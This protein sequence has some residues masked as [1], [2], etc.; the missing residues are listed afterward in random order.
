MRSGEIER[1][2]WLCVV[3]GGVGWLWEYVVGYCGGWLGDRG[4]SWIT[5][6]E[7]GGDRCVVGV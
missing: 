7:W 6:D 1:G 2:C 5:R 3:G 4:E